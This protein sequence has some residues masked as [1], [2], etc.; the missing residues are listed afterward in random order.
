VAIGFPPSFSE[1]LL[2]SLMKAKIPAGAFANRG[3]IPVPIPSF[4]IKNKSKSEGGKRRQR[5]DKKF[6]L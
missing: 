4:P 2:F 3:A 5:V 1:I 6:Q